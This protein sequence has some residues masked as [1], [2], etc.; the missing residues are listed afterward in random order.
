MVG[1]DYSESMLS[2]V[3]IHPV[4]PFSP[5]DF[6]TALLQRI[7]MTENDWVTLRVSHFRKVKFNWL[8][9]KPKRIS[10]WEKFLRMLGVVYIIRL[11]VVTNEVKMN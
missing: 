5:L 6:L 7:T 9:S 11:N 4:S 10:C 3:R 2:V 8:Y 1:I